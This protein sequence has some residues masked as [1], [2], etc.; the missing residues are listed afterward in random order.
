MTTR[1][2]DAWHKFIASREY[3]LGYQAFTEQESH[4]RYSTNDAEP[5]TEIMQNLAGSPP[6]D[7]QY[8]GRGKPRGLNMRAFSSFTV[9]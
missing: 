8:L 7:L 4:G 1:Y 2:G 3:H 6:T 9:F 5:D